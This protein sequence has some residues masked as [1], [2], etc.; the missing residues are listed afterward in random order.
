MENVTFLKQLVS[1][2][3]KFSIWGQLKQGYERSQNFLNPVFPFENIYLNGFI[4]VIIR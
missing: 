3:S 2:N 1:R 4:T